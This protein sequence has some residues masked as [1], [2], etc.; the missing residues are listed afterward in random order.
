[1]AALF[2]ECCKLGVSLPLDDSLAP[3]TRSLTSAAAC[4]PTCSRLTSPVRDM[5]RQPGR[6]LTSKASSVP[7]Q[8]FHRAVI[9]EGGETVEHGLGPA[10][11]WLGDMA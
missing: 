7:T 9:A 2:T 1:M 8:A 11:A 6:P 4:R 5:L 10:P 3:A